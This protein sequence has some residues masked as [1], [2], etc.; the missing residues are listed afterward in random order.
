VGAE[1]RIVPNKLGIFADG[2]W[3]YYGDNYGHD[4]QNNFL[5][6]AGVRVVF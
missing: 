3:N 1:Y 2:R 6:R 4:V 5:F